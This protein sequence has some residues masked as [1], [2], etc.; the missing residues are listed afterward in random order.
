MSFRYKGVI[1]SRTKT[2]KEMNGRKEANTLFN[3]TFK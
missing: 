2:E 3:K 1:F